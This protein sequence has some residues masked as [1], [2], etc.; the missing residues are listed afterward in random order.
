MPE[1]HQEAHETPTESCRG[2]FRIG[3]ACGECP[4]CRAE[5]F[6]PEERAEAIAA[7]TERT[8]DLPANRVKPN[9]PDIKV[10]VV[11]PVTDGESGS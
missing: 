11:M 8:K 9:H 5:G 4:R 3:T 2:S 10:E 6:G 1:G 7:E